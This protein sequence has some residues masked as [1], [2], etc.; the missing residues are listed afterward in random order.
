MLVSQPHIVRIVSME[1]RDIMKRYHKHKSKNNNL[2]RLNKYSLFFKHVHLPSIS[3]SYPWHESK[4]V[5]LANT[6]CF[7][8]VKTCVY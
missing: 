1:T 7:P 8:L 4:K 5:L 6:R 2:V 3:K